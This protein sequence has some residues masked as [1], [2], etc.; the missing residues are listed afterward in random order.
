MEMI[1][2]YLTV[3]EASEYL[4]C[5]PRTLRRCLGKVL[6]Y[7]KFQGKILL[8]KEDIERYMDKARVSSINETIQRAVNRG[9]N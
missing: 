1:S 5:H 3:A 2:P 8:R 4:K 6:P 9:R 7:H